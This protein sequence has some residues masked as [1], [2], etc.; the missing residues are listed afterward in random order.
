ME[1]NPE[2]PPFLAPAGESRKAAY[3]RVMCL[4]PGVLD[5]ATK[6]DWRKG[7]VLANRFHKF[8]N[9]S[10]PEVL[11]GMVGWWYQN[12]HRIRKEFAYFAKGGP[13]L[14][15]VWLMADTA[16]HERLKA[17]EGAC[18]RVGTAESAADIISRLLPAGLPYTEQEVAEARAEALPPAPDIVLPPRRDG[19]SVEESLEAEV[20]R[21]LES[22]PG[23]PK[24][25]EK[26]D[27][28]KDRKKRKRW[29]RART[30]EHAD[31]GEV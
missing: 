15:A 5:G 25:G 6:N 27:P 26:R 28:P 17:G 7:F 14:R 31:K 24:R 9:E 30:R 16:Y 10:R 13:A 19:A 23:R 22:S 8:L 20:R 1:K 3:M 11:A 29:E 4:V 21:V 18:V 2:A 12:R